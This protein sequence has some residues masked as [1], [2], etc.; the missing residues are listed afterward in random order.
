MNVLITSA[1]AKV[2]LVQA[3][4]RA[5]ARLGGRVLTTD[6]AAS[7]AA[8]LFSDAHF[9][10]KPINAEGALDELLLICA[11]NEVRLIVPT[12]DGELAFFAQHKQ[13][14]AAAGVAVLV[15]DLH[16]LRVCQ[17]KRAF[18]QAIA[19]HG[20]G[21]LP[22][23]DQPVTRFPAFVRPAEGAG[24]RGV[25]RIDD[26]AELAT[27]GNLTDYLVHPL[28]VAPEY[29]ID[30]LMDLD[31]RALQAVVRERGQVVAGESRVSTVVRHDRLETDTLR[32]GEALG[33]VGHNTVQAFDDRER[34]LLFIEVNPRF[35]GA[36]NCSIEAGLQS[37]DRLLALLDGDEGARAPR[38]IRYGLTMYRYA[39]DVFSGGAS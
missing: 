18:G 13:R 16:R 12:R 17:D 22:V 31:G 20:L 15:P 38:A 37:P 35:G 24:G 32:L 5:A 3:F 36:S 27:V 2:L 34:G 25:R 9:K 7:C 33:L 14:F 19:A 28:I 10:V 6:M 39:Q 4:Q 26:A 30:L 8:G 29:S 1:A 23:L 11:T 21:A